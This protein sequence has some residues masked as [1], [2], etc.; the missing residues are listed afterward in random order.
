MNMRK[1]IAEVVTAVL[2]FLLV[3]PS[4]AQEK[5]EFSYTVGRRVVI[6]I[7]NNYGPIS[8]GPSGNKRVLVTTVSHSAAVSFANEQRGRHIELRASSSRQGTDLADYRVLVPSGAV[9]HLRSSGGMLQAH[10]LRGG[11]VIL[12]STGAPAQVNDASNIHVHM[13]TLSGPIEL[14]D[15]RDSHLEVL[16]VSGNVRIH[17]VSGSWI[18]VNSGSGQITYEGDPGTGG[19]YQLTSHSGDIE[20]SIPASSPVQINARAFN[21]ESDLGLPDSGTVGTMGQGNLLLPPGIG[22]ASRFVLRSFRG[23]IRLSRPI[24]K[25]RPNF[26]PRP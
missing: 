11:D 19:D 8:V 26:E 10:G 21:D 13:K 17:E 18:E 1:T 25:S 7:T 22:G 4:S 24:D 20:V 16:S 3:L 12:E 6:S 23:K 15:V 9:V 5:K 14:D 2:I